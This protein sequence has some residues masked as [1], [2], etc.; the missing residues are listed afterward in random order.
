MRPVHLI[1]LALA[2]LGALGFACGRD[3]DLPPEPLPPVIQGGGCVT[4][5][6]CEEGICSADHVCDPT[7]CH[8]DD[9]CA[10]GRC[11]PSGTCAARS[12]NQDADCPADS[13]CHES[14]E[15]DSQCVT[16][17]RNDENCSAGK[18]CT[19]T[20][21]VPIGL[22]VTPGCL[23]DSDCPNCTAC[24]FDGGIYGTCSTEPV[25]PPL[26]GNPAALTM[27]DNLEAAVSFVRSRDPDAQL[28]QINGVGLAS[29]GTVDITREGDY[30]SRWI[31]GF[32]IGD[33][34]SGPPRFATVS[35]QLQGGSHCGLYDGNAGN[36]SAKPFIPDEVWAQYLDSP[37]L[38]SAFLAQSGCVAPMRDFGDYVLYD[39]DGTPPEF[40]LGNWKSQFV[41]GDP[42]T[43]TLRYVSC[44]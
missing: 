42:V 26:L 17:C 43:G 40:L 16:G 12:C 8:R 30:F 5:D 23:L 21:Q 18:T 2:A 11:R 1:A 20:T 29:D 33:G 19:A 28:I 24:V 32:Q 34:S 3:L 25:A 15:G 31:Y 22:C 10:S 39:H 41:M 13:Y 4:D 27:R 38:V 6:D 44:P 9:Q 36:L 35:Y 37:Q 14:P 7:R